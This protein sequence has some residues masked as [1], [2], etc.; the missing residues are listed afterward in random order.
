MPSASGGFGATREQASEATGPLIAVR[1]FAG[2]RTPGT[3]DPSD[4]LVPDR[5]SDALV[6]VA[7]ALGVDGSPETALH[8]GSD[9]AVRGRRPR[10][11]CPCA[12]AVMTR[13][14]P[15]ATAILAV[16]EPGG[17]AT[18]WRSLLLVTADR[19][20]L[21]RPEHELRRHR[22]MAAQAATCRTTALFAGRAVLL[23]PRHPS[24][25]LR[26]TRR[27]FSP[28]RRR[29]TGSRR[30]PEIDPG[31]AHAPRRWRGASGLRASARAARSC[32]PSTWKTARRCSTSGRRSRDAC[33]GTAVASC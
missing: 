22:R 24:R 21:T 6:H 27:T 29:S 11:R 17:P 25:R 28:G 1:A 15:A 19:A 26:P 13:R 8:I 20:A 7:S 14:P 3:H 23:G 12:V 5:P 18:G 10:R 30:S 9:A 32:W 2:L 16:V 33:I 4:F 31:L